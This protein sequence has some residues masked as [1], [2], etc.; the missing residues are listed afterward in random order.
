MAC[1]TRRRIHLSALL[2]LASA[3]VRVVQA[4][5]AAA[6]ASATAAAAAAG[7]ATTAGP[8]YSRGRPRKAA[9]KAKAQAVAAKAL[10]KTSRAAAKVAAE[11]A[12]AVGSSGVR[13]LGCA[14]RCGAGKIEVGGRERQ[15]LCHLC[16]EAGNRVATLLRVCVMVAGTLQL[17]FVAARR[18]GGKQC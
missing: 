11:A 14:I 10:V 6:A 18:L 2:D 1:R 9:A 7:A 4:A 3:E 15:R 12:V 16:E 5:A 17:Y 8:A 13:T